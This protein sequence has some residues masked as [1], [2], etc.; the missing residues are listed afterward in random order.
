M[1]K[2]KEDRGSILGDGDEDGKSRWTGE[3]LGDLD[4]QDLLIVG[5]WEGWNRLLVSER[6][7][8]HLLS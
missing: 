4:Q 1:T 5:L 2:A 3:R 8:L 7:Q 6:A